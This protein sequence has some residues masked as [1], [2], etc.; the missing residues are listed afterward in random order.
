VEEGGAGTMTWGALATMWEILAP[1]WCQRRRARF[2]RSDSEGLTA[3]WAGRQN[4][5]EGHNREEDS[6]NGTLTLIK[7]SSVRIMGKPD[8][9]GSA[10]G[11]RT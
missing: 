4:G 10:G 9:V 6:G 8:K 5:G 7:S 2:R 3:S 11:S 1:G